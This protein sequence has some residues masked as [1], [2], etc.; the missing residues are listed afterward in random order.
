MSASWAAQVWDG[1]ALVGGVVL[2]ILCLG[3]VAW[4]LF[5]PGK[6]WRLRRIPG[7]FGWPVFGNMVSLAQRDMA[8]FVLDGSAKYGKV[9]KFWFGSIPW[10]VVDDADMARR[11]LNKYINRPTLP[12]VWSGRELDIQDAI[13]VW[14]RGSTWRLGRKAFEHAVLSPPVLVRRDVA[15][16]RMGTAPGRAVALPLAEGRR[17]PVRAP[18]QP[19]GG[20]Q[21]SRL[22]VAANV[23]PSFLS[24]S[25]HLCRPQPARCTR[26]NNFWCIQLGLPHTYY[27]PRPVRVVHAGELHSADQ[28]MRR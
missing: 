1:C 22:E 10:V 17:C 25:V 9:W 20:Q 12:T 8:G 11:I 26:T 4:L 24:F 16:R 23:F 13:L 18:L 14:A 5:F 19:Q 15:S 7:P 21:P 28:C 2:E 27:A 3:A 6:R